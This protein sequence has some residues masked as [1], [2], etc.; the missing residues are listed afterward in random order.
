[1]Q[2]YGESVEMLVDFFGTNACINQD[3]GVAEL[4]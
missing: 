1:M 4:Q 3:G 2:G